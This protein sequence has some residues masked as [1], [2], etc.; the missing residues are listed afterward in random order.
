M[1]Y[2][3]MPGPD[4]KQYCLNHKKKLLARQSCT[5][6]EEMVGA[7]S[8]ALIKIGRTPA[9]VEYENWAGK[10][11]FNHAGHEGAHNWS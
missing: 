10:D 3:S 8:L 4:R 9:G 2:G 7:I 5:K 11:S 6:Y 1:K